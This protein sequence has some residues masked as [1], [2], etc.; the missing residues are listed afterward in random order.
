MLDLWIGSHICVYAFLD[1]LQV[2]DLSHSFPSTTSKQGFD[3]G[4][5]PVSLSSGYQIQRTNH[6]LSLT[7]VLLR[8]D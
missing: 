7:I 4:N 2:W 6:L 5:L 1:L 8:V 3:S